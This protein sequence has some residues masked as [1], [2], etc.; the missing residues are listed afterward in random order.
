[1]KR[2]RS[3]VML[4]CIPKCGYGDLESWRHVG[5]YLVCSCVDMKSSSCVTVE[6]SK[7]VDGEGCACPVIDMEIWK[8]GEAWSMPYV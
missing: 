6:N 3:V 7:L 4:T 5:V 1:M 8:L 2:L